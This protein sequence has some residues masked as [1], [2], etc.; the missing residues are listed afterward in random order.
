MEYA[1]TCSRR[2]EIT[3]APMMRQINYNIQREKKGTK[4]SN[5][6]VM[7]MWKFGVMKLRKNEVCINRKKDSDKVLAVMN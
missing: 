7:L 2:D 1:R 4:I 5:V 6:Y 3:K